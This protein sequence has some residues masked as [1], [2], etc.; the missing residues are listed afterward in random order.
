[1]K[2]ISK[3]VAEDLMST[4]INQLELEIDNVMKTIQ[5][6][7]YCSAQIINQ[8]EQLQCDYFEFQN[9]IKSQQDIDFTKFNNRADSIMDDFYLIADEY[10]DC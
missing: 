6:E 5:S 1:M 9:I 2:Q 10:R 3:A 8:A 7:G 4:R